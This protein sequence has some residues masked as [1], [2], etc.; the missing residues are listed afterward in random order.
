MTYK[1]YVE[2][3]MG[4]SPEITKYADPILAASIGLGS[5]VTSAYAAY[6]IGMPGFKGF[7]SGFKAFESEG[8]PEYPMRLEE[9]NFEAF[10]GGNC[11]LARYFVKGLI[12]NAIDGGTGLNEV[13]GR[14]VNFSALDD[15]ANQVRI[16]TRSTVVFVKHEGEASK[17]SSVMIAY[18]RKGRAERLRARRVVMA[19]GNWV[20][21]FA[22]RDLPLEYLQACRQFHRS[23]MLVVNVALRHWR[24]LYDLGLTACR[25]FDGFGFACNIRRAMVVEGFRQPL[26]PD[27][28]VVLTFYVPFYYPGKDIAQ[29]GIMG[30]TELLST[31]YADYEEQIRGQMS[32]LF[33][34]AG[35][36]AKK[37]IAG[38]VLNRWGHAYVDPQPGFYFGVDG[39]PAPNE[40]LRKGFGR[41]SIG[42]SELRGFQNWIGAVSEGR[43]AA[44]EVLAIGD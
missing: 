37:D 7:Q 20:N 41:I 35:F 17:S 12:P 18:V 10:P 16:R 28:P 43:R 26:D 6:S 5:D 40:A 9:M 33:G 14:N 4:L 25:W 19:C 11:G 32:K 21:Q 42:H 3:I 15:A 2:E 27:R 13:I 34:N 23:P 39:K 1:R 22:I 31:S 36:D 24:F 8:E 29:Q 30:R 38:I 44:R